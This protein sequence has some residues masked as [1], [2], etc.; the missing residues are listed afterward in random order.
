MITVKDIGVKVD[1]VWPRDRARGGINCH[2]RKVGRFPQLVE[3]PLTEGIFKIELP[4]EAVG[5]SQAET[6]VTQMFNLRNAG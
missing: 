3:E 2:A 6:E 4:D 5:E 1:L